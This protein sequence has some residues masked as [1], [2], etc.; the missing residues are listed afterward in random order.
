MKLSFYI[1]LTSV[2]KAIKHIPIGYKSSSHLCMYLHQCDDLNY[3][4]MSR[5]NVIRLHRR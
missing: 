3:S 5:V 4:K 1:T 2:L